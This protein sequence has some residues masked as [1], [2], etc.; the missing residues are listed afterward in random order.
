ME[1]WLRHWKIKQDFSVQTTIKKD[2]T[3]YTAG[4]TAENIQILHLKMHNA[5]QIVWNYG[6]GL[7]C[8]LKVNCFNCKIQKMRGNTKL[9]VSS[10]RRNAQYH[11]FN[12]WQY[13]RKSPTSCGQ[14][15]AYRALTDHWCSLILMLTI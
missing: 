4:R 12:E 13:I 14:L 1:M 8:T 2:R 3:L 11:I 10:H 6:P 9:M 5:K 15:D 7:V